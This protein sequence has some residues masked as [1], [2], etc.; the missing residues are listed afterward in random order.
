MTY[1]V[2]LGGAGAVLP[3]LLVVR[4]IWTFALPENVLNLDAP[5]SVCIRNTVSF[6]N[7]QFH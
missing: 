7:I 4:R 5:V 1:L 6:F 2:L 3:F